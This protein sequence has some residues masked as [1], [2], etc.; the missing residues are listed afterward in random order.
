MEVAR[1]RSK[2][3]KILSYKVAYNGLRN[4]AIHLDRCVTRLL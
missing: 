3:L 2:E 4:Y 1:V